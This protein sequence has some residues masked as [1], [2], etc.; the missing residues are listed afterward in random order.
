MLLT[1]DEVNTRLESPLN[2]VN[3]IVR[4]QS[5][6]AE[7]MDNIVPR[8]PSIE[9]LVDNVEDK[10]RLVSAHGKAIKAL[11]QSVTAINERIHEVEK[12]KDL[13]RIARD[14]SGIVSSIDEM[15][16]NRSS[17]NGNN[18]IIFQPII[19]KEDHYETIHVHE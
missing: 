5:D 11:D 4:H 18:L 19:M 17:R 9:E 7:L 6:K 8:T 12:A 16:N 14:M 1:E 10:I 2:L 15:R 3:Q 13:S